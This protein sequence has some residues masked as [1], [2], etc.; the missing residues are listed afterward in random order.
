M[1]RSH[2]LLLVSAVVGLAVTVQSASARPW[3]VACPSSY[4]AF[5]R[6][7][8]VIEGHL[9]VGVN[10]TAYQRYLGN[11]RIAY[12][13]LPTSNVAHSCISLVGVPGEV[14][15]NDYVKAGNSWAAC[16]A[17]I[18]SGLA[19]NGCAGPGTYGNGTRQ[20]YWSDATANIQRAVNNLS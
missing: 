8:T 7:L 17:R 18:I 19:P 2:S 5:V 3:G 20:V 1:R 16:N 9:Q 14:A 10:Y 13:Q 12:N 11:A 15:M 4:R 6:S